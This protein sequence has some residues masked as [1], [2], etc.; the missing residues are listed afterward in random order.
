MAVQ[1]FTDGIEP[2]DPDTP[3][4]RF[5]QWEH[6]Q[7]LMTG[8][9]YF[10][11]GDLLGDEHEGLPLDDYVGSFPDRYD[12]NDIQRRN[13]ALGFDAQ[14]RQSY[15]ISCWTLF[16]NDTAKMWH[17]YAAGNGV[18]IVSTYS[19]L[20]SVLDPLPDDDKAMMGLIR[21]G[22]DHLIPGRRN[23]M[24]N[25]STKRVQFKGEK[26]VRAMLWIVDPH[27][28]GNRHIDIDN[29]CHPRPIYPTSNPEFVRRRVD[30]PSLITRVIV[31]PFADATAY[32]E[33]VRAVQAGGYAFPVE[34]SD[35][36]S[37]AHLLPTADEL[38]KLHYL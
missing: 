30:M 1:R 29:R 21:Y 10:C 31:S 4:C 25:V 19:R 32:D 17:T 18:M 3:I 13:D 23:L 2:D 12:L 15:F 27:E 6:F 5:Y 9:I 33:T 16:G 7:D 20:K 22:A 8:Q 37:H 38:R 35:M 28:T 24:V 14:I 34:R 36:T 11:R 26:E